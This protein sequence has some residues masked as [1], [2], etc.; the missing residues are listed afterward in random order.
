MRRICLTHVWIRTRTCELGVRLYLQVLTQYPRQFRRFQKQIWFCAT[1]FASRFL[2]FWGCEE[3][4]F[5]R[6]SRELVHSI[7]TTSPPPYTNHAAECPLLNKLPVTI[8]LGRHD[9]PHG[10]RTFARRLYHELRFESTSVLSCSY[11]C[12]VAE[13]YLK[14]AVISHQAS[15]SRALDIIARTVHSAL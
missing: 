3:S 14:R 13:S 2:T 11:V 10:E 1:V 6:D 15:S 7:N 12:M 4:W 5:G 9:L 8:K